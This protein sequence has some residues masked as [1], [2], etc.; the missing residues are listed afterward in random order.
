MKS[1]ALFI[2]HRRFNFHMENISLKMIVGSD[3]KLA[4]PTL[5]SDLTIILKKYFHYEIQ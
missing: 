4:D 3:T 2:E 1:R 5:E